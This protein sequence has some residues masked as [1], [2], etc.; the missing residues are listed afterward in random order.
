MADDAASSTPPADQAA[1]DPDEK[2]EKVDPRILQERLAYLVENV[3]FVFRSSKT[4]NCV[5][6]QSTR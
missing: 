3:S 2:E 4:M 5:V 6:S 1:K